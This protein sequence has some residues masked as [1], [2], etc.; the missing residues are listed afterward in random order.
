MTDIK[1]LLKGIKTEHILGII[2][3]VILLLAMNNYNNGKNLFQAGYSN[4]QKPLHPS[5]L[6]DSPVENKIS[7]GTYAPYNGNQL[8]SV[9]TSAD[10][11][12]SMNGQVSNKSIANPSDLLPSDKNSSWAALNPASG[13]LQNINLLNPT[14]IVGINTQGSSLRNA[15]LQLRSEPPNPR[16]NTNCPWNQTTI[17]SDQIRKQLEIGSMA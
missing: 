8:S 14:Q 10:S 17:E 1:K 5:V 15:N 3:L 7:T 13:D 2:G 12:T 9:A 16:M 6:N 4:V 11:P